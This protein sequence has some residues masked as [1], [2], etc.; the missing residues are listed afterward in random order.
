M[1]L[2][3]FLLLAAI[4]IQTPQAAT[5]SVSLN[6]N[7][8][9]TAEQTANGNFAFNISGTGTASSLGQVT[10]IGTGT[11]AQLTQ[12]IVG[13]LTLT[14]NSGEKLN[15][16]FS[17]PLGILF[18]LGGDS[19]LATGSA[20]VTG[21]TGQYTGATGMFPSITGSGTATGITSSNFQLRGDGSVTTLPIGPVIS[22]NGVVS[23][24]DY[25]GFKTIAPGTWIEIY[26]TNLSTTTRQW[27]GA[28]FSNNGQTAPTS[29][30]GVKVTAGGQPAFV[31][32]VSPGQ[33]N[34]LVA[35]NAVTGAAQLTV[36]NS[37]GTTV[38][39]NITIASVAPGLLAPSSLQFGGKQYVGALMTNT[40]TI[41]GIPTNGV[42]AGDAITIFGIGFGPVTPRVDAGTVSSQL[43]ALATMPQILFGTTL[44]DLS[45][46]GLAP[47]FTGL[48]QLNL[49]VPAVAA[50]V[51]VP[52]TFNLGG[53]AGAQTLYITIQQ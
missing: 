44:T 52:L 2:G 45:Y 28:D 35:S 12:P 10:F 14:F 47:G 9:G 21:G 20:S 1:R 49:K 46:Y 32:Y 34:A 13:S 31:Q 19:G 38:P 4:F 27:A 39:Y 40:Q 36:A 51:A 30:D 15:L 23:A 41:V 7:G 48:Y 33:V 50:N 26:G 5:T 8:S 37:L 43:T 17:I 25:G 22:A 18:P 3:F 42:R 29:L 16:N 24:L 6:L 11:A 53:M